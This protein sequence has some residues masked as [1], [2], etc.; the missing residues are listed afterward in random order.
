MARP[1]SFELVTPAIY[2]DLLV[3]AASGSR[4]DALSTSPRGLALMTSRVSVER[5]NIRSDSRMR[6]M[7]ATLRGLSDRG[8]P[9]PPRSRER[10]PD[11]PGVLSSGLRV[12]D[13]PGAAQHH[14]FPRVLMVAAYEALDSG[15]NDRVDTLCRQALKAASGLPTPLEGPPI[16]IDAFT[17]RAEASLAAGAYADAVA[18]YTHAAELAADGYPGLP[19]SF[20]PTA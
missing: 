6:S 4:K 18:A 7:P 17:L 1:R 20:L 19:L 12:L 15:D 13:L 3:E 16:E 2:G 11:R 14:D 5:D 9:S 10:E 8:Q